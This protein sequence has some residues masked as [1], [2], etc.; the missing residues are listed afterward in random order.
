MN[1]F[2]KQLGQKNTTTWN[3]AISNS[4]S[5]SSVLDYF[6]KCGSYRGRPCEAVNADMASVFGTD[7]VQAMKTVLYNRMVT[8]R[9]KGFGHTT[10]SVQKGQGQRDEFIKSLAWLE[11]NRPNYL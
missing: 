1:K 7:P 2:V 4:T 3:G 8:R 5:G 11:N 9:I 10:E 6:A